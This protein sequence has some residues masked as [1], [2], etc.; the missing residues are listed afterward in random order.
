L[1][2]PLRQWRKYDPTR[3]YL[4]E[5]ELKRILAEKDISN[6]VYEIAS[7]SLS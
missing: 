4:M 7:K 1:L 2:T 5:N 6:D 3:K